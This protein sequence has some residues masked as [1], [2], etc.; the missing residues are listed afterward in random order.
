MSI[1]SVFHAP[2]GV[3]TKSIFP[4]RLRSGGQDVRVPRIEQLSMASGTFCG[5][6]VNGRLS[7]AIGSV[8]PAVFCM[9]GSKPG[10]NRA[11]GTKFCEPLPEPIP[12][13]QKHPARRW[14]VEQ[15]LGWL[16]KRRSIRTRWC[17]NSENWLTFVQF[18]CVHILCDLAIYG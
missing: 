17:K 10:S 1:I 15:T 16:A 2:C 9:K 8:F 11:F 18:A 6:A 4:S 14:V 3:A 5:Q 13:D 12:D 7:I